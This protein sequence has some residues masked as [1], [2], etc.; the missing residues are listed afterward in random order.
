MPRALGPG[1][2]C[3]ADSM[4]KH[5]GGK[6]AN[7]AMLACSARDGVPGPSR[8]GVFLNGAVGADEPGS[9]L[10]EHL[11][12]CGVDISRV[13]IMAGEA[14]ATGIVMLKTV[15]SDSRS[16]A[17][18]GAISS[19]RMPDPST[20]NCLTSGSIPDLIVAN[21]T[22]PQEEVVKVFT[23]A[24]REGETTVFN[25]SPI[26]EVDR[27][28]FANVTH[29]ILN[30]SEAA[31]LRQVDS[32]L[33]SDQSDWEETTGFFLQLGVSNVVPTLAAE[34][35]YYATIDGESGHVKAVQGV[36]VVDA[37]GAG[38]SFIGAYAVEYVRQ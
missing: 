37:T 19:W 6:G 24:A 18:H 15:I 25:P 9:R 21:L 11:K 17:Y 28:I 14:T 1:E 33:L 10:L 13:R 32:G 8:I 2:S 34:G 5:P 4:T 36:Q 3:P 16:F 35:A 31:A 26:Q 12:R 22:A 38:D 23:A 29:L 30:Q 27:V 20:V 7:I